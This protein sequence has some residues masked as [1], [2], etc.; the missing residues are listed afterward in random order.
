MM[1][2]GVVW[3]DVMRCDMIY[4]MVYDVMWR[5]MTWYDI[6]YNVSDT[7]ILIFI[8]ISIIYEFYLTI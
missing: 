1:W 3:C 2:C 4:S 6:W 7:L 8:Y 5:D